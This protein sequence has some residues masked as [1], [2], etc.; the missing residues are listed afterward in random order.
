MEKN[1]KHDYSAGIEFK[2]RNKEN[3]KTIFRT[4][5]LKVKNQNSKTAL[6]DKSRYLILASPKFHEKCGIPLKLSSFN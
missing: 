3:R 1:T 2:K 6:Y 5:T 4:S